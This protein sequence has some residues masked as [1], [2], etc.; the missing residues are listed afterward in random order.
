MAKEFQLSARAIPLD[1]RYDVIVAGGGPAGCGAAA[2]A[3]RQG[4][5]TL[6]IEANGALGGMGTLGL[7][8]FFCGFGDGATFIARGI[9]EQVRLRLIEGTPHMRNPQPD[10]LRF[11]PSI[12]PERLKRIYDDLVTA[13]GADV[14]FHTA[15]VGVERGAGGVEALLA[16]N[17]EGLSALRARVYIDAT[18]DGDLAAWAGAPFEKGD[19]AGRLQPATLCFMLANADLYALEKGPESSWATTQQAVR[20]AWLSK[21]HPLIEDAHCCSRLLGADV[22]G[23]NA[24]H[25]YGVDNTDP[26]SVSQALIRGRRQA[27]QYRAVLAARH[28]GYANAWLAA[29]AAVLGVRE[30]R[31]I[32]GDYVL[33]IDDYR[34]RRSFPDEIC[35]NAYNIDVHGSKKTEAGAA[36]TDAE[37]RRRQMAAEIEQY[38]DGESYGVPYRC[39]TPR[40]LGNVLTAGRCISTDR[41]INGSVRI[42]ACC[43]TTGE[44]AGAAAAL[45]AQG[46]GDVHAVDTARLRAVLRE[47]G[48]YLPGPA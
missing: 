45:A 12:D 18:G 39:L 22:Y 33:T 4:A 1:D 37:T 5:R 47:H 38:S 15:L 29:T 34:A 36:D 44:A 27:E 14:L 35:R 43:L 30:T 20:E 26:A 25:V 19:A 3:A 11:W 40:G 8:P 21:Q 6:L 10:W 7:V 46:D 24:G 9:A 28:P 2:A 31:R 41:R 23:F 16:A 13:A 32:M 42:M 48:A 17:K